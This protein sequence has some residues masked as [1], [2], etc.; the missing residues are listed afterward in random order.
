MELDCNWR[1]IVCKE[2]FW[3]DPESDLFVLEDD[4][5][6]DYCLEVLKEEMDMEVLCQDGSGSL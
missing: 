6:C 3:D 4:I 5:W 1:C 2:I